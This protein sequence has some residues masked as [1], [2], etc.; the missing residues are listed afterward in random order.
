MKNLLFV[1]LIFASIGSFGIGSK[2]IKIENITKASPI[3]ECSYIIM[4]HL[5]FN[6]NE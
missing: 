4:T 5:F 1:L 3:V 2:G 6:I